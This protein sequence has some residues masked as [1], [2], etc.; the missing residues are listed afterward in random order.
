MLM[1]LTF[2]ERLFTLPETLVMSVR[3]SFQR[4]RSRSTWPGPPRTRWSSTGGRTWCWPPGQSPRSWWTSW[5]RTAVLC[6]TPGPS[7]SSTPTSRGPS[8]TS[9][10]SPTDSGAPPLWPPWPPSLTTWVRA[11]SV[12][13][14]CTPPLVLMSSTLPLI[15]NWSLRRD[16][17]LQLQTTFKIIY[18]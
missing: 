12:W 17:Q 11:S 7:P 1:W 5:T 6:V 13:I 16:D 2:Q 18:C 14:R 9:L 8:H 15:P 4:E 3:Q 10:W